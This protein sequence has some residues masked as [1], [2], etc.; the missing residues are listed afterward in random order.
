MSNFKFDYEKN[1]TRK[2]CTE[3]KKDLNVKIKKIN[4]LDAGVSGGS[5]SLLLFQSNAQSKE[6][7]VN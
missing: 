1:Q 4:V 2:P 7:Q 5:L 3:H 6:F